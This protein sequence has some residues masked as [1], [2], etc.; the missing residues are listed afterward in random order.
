MAGDDDGD[1]ADRGAVPSGGWGSIRAV[2]GILAREGHAASTTLTLRRQNKDGG[3]MCVSCAWAKP[4]PPHL[5]E[6]CENGAKATAWDLTSARITADF[7]ARHSVT[8][9]EGWSDHALE[10]AGRLID[11]MR[12]DPDTDHY[13]PATWEEA[14]SAIG[15]ALRTTAPDMT[16]FYTSGRASNEAAYMYQLLARL[17]G[18]NNLPDSSNM[19]HE[20]TSVGL[21]QAIGVP[22]GTVTLD[23]FAQTDLIMIFGQNT[24]TNSP[25]MLHQLEDAARRGVPI[26][27][28]NTLRERGLDY[29][30]NPQNPLR[31]LAHR[32]TPIATRV[33]QPRPGGDLALLTG[34]CKQLLEWDDA[35]SLIDGVPALDHAFIHEHTHGFADFVRAMKAHDWQTIVRRSGL[36]RTAIS[37][38]ATF[39]RN[40]TKV[41]G[42]YGMGLTQ[43]REGVENVRMLASLLLLRGN[44]GRPGAGICP[45]RGHSNVQGQRSVWIT[46]KPELAPL[47]QMARL[48]GFSP[49][50]H[51]GLDVVEAAEKVIGGDVKAVIQLGGNLVRSLPEHTL[52]VPAWRRLEL[53]VMITTRLNRSHLIHG[54]AAWLLP[55]LSRVEIDRQAS[56]PQIV[57]IEDSTSCIHASR[58][59]RQPAGTNLRSEPAIIAGI[60]NALL[61]PNPHVPWQEWVADYARIRNAIAATYPEWYADY[62]QRLNQPGGFYRGND[63]RQRRWKTASGK[64][65]FLPLA[66]L[67]ADPDMPAP[68]DGFVLV[69][70]RSNDQFNTTIYGY[71]DRFRNVKGTRQ[72]VMMCPDDMAA[73]G[74]EPGATVVLET[75]ADDRVR[76]E[77]TGLRIVPF[78]LPRGTLA[79]YYPEC[80]ALLPLWH[81]ARES[82]VPAAKSIPVR[83]RPAAGT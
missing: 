65:N 68:Q 81:R 26:L 20:S 39:Y 66:S 75:I 58:G 43:H 15:T 7:F 21:P 4:S 35:E 5:A 67:E 51:K 38:I 59:L 27:V 31:M 40:A 24:A 6:F 32:P 83:L 18:T 73:R 63:A 49:P 56:G 28:V 37:E 34:L 9:L 19:C 78:D 64:A 60:A 16:V 3:F 14:F 44:I 47:D 42:L 69:T 13:V 52:L 33:Y 61:P 76:R 17:Y 50:R 36:S 10:Q 29:F 82:H 62:N 23:D 41:L 8:E 45:V 70:V 1:A 54:R 53:T 71:D 48:Y 46:E 2:A 55:C 72:V 12:W 57:S 25:R 80:N 74:L 22:V 79:A 30:V 77:V 11:P